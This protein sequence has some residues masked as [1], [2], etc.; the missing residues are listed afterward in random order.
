MHYLTELCV[1]IN[2]FYYNLYKDYQR[3]LNLIHPN[4]VFL[5]DDCY[6]PG[7]EGECYPIIMQ[8]LF[9]VDYIL[10]R[11]KIY[12]PSEVHQHLR[13]L[14]SFVTS[15]LSLKLPRD[16]HRGIRIHAQLIEIA[17][18]RL[19]EFINQYDYKLSQPY[20]ANTALLMVS[21]LFESAK[22]AYRPNLSPDT[23]LVRNIVSGETLNLTSLATKIAES[24]KIT[25]RNLQFIAIGVTSNGALWATTNYHTPVIYPLN[26]LLSQDLYKI[27][28]DFRNEYK[29]SHHQKHTGRLTFSSHIHA[30]TMLASLR[31]KLDIK[32]IF[33]ID[34]NGK[35]VENCP[36]CSHYLCTQGFSCEPHMEEIKNYQLPTSLQITDVTDWAYAVQNKLT[37][38][39]Y[40][41]IPFV[42]DHNALSEEAIRIGTDMLKQMVSFI[43]YDQVDDDLP[44]LDQI[45]LTIKEHYPFS[46]IDE[47]GLKHTYNTAR[48]LAEPEADELNRTIIRAN[49]IQKRIPNFRLK[50]FDDGR[51][52]SAPDGI[53]LE[54]A[55]PDSPR[56]VLLTDKL[57][58]WSKD[59]HPSIQFGEENTLSTI[60]M[61]RTS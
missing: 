13:N 42:L 35:K 31:N 7:G 52:K 54:P 60:T 26:Y 45:F 37:Q 12:S 61:R 51:L 57:N 3:L 53:N 56:S 34:G 8:D 38:N 30:E 49:T 14:Q 22:Q 48:K 6:I 29:T 39:T 23:P 18:K 47:N 2:N 58:T 43:P 59:K 16:A 1:D 55:N 15:A 33:I 28:Q 41:I 25:Q 44:Q 27:A 17:S 50:L 9:S 10:T 46:L 20:K 5:N 24:T 19:N 40:E 4:R 21:M 11:M 36:C 32:H